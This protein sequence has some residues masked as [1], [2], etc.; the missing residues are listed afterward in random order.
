GNQ[1]S[2][3][4]VSKNVAL[5]I[6]S[7]K[8]NQLTSLDVSSCTALTGLECCDNQL[9]SLN[10]SGCRNLEYLDC[11]GNQLSSLDVSK[12]VALEI[13]SCGGNQLTSL[14]VSSCTALT[15]LRPWGMPTLYEVC[16]WESFPAGVEVATFG[17]P[18]VQF[19]TDCATNI[20]NDYNENRT[21]D[22]YPNPSDD[23]INIEIENI[24]NA[25][26]EIYNVSGMLV[27]SKA[28]NSKVEKIDVSGLLEGIYFVKV[29]QAGG[30]HVGKVVV[31]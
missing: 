5:E 21:V 6:L 27:F 1:L 13:L 23:I 16:I 14:D 28:L 30:V 18:N 8:R 31:K 15:D 3:L 10:V 29:R 22:I 12:N 9:I 25:T 4:D 19:T 11:D 17:N 24:N 26:I 7:C 2:S 20:K